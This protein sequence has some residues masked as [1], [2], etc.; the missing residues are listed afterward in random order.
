MIGVKLGFAVVQKLK[1]CLSNYF[2]FLLTVMLDQAGGLLP[3]AGDPGNT[4]SDKSTDM[5]DGGKQN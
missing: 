4:Q 1:S 2:P 3:G 5:G